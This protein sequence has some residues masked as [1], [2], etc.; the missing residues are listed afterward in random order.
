MTNHWLVRYYGRIEVQRFQGRTTERCCSV[1]S[2]RNL[3][4]ISGRETW[5]V[6]GRSGTRIVMYN[7]NLAMSEVLPCSVVIWTINWESKLD[8]EM[9]QPQGINPWR[10]YVN[11]W[12]SKKR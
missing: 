9:Y 3:S 12:G 8:S 4:N 11:P 2:A 5:K 1:V 7:S 6:N 10:T